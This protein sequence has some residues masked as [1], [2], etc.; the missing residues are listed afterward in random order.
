VQ[1]QARRH[2]VGIPVIVS[3]D[4][5]HHFSNNP[6][7][8]LMA[9]PFAQF[10]EPLGP[11]ALGSAEFVE[12]FAAIAGYEHLAVASAPRCTRSSTFGEDAEPAA[13]LGVAYIRGLQGDAVGPRSG[14]G[15]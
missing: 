15:T 5:R 3:S 10:P 6:A 9:G 14:C 4:P 11:A 13:R 2:P 8:M 7:A 1:E 12:R